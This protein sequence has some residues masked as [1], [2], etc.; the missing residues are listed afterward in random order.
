MIKYLKRC[1]TK[2]NKHL[3]LR[4]AASLIPNVNCTLVWK[5]AGKL[6]LKK[7]QQQICM[8]T[9]T[10]SY[11]ITLNLT[12]A[13]RVWRTWWC[14]AMYLYVQS[15]TCY[16]SSRTFGK[17]IDTWQCWFTTI[18]RALPTYLVLIRVR[19]LYTSFCLDSLEVVH[20]KRRNTF[21][22]KCAISDNRIIQG[23]LGNVQI[24]T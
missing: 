19:F 1:G 22:L 7:Q 2:Q 18:G 3:V 8:E 16:P 21:L 13:V 9:M 20:R 17:R 14:K 4:F 11:N 6:I 15:K 10:C 12:N 23:I 24:I 5:L